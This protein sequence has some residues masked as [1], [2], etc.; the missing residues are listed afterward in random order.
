M[1]NF[2]HRERALVGY[3]NKDQADSDL[4]TKQQIA[5]IYAKVAAYLA[6]NDMTKPL[7]FDT[8]T[9]GGGRDDQMIEIAICDSERTLIVDTLVYTDRPSNPEAFK[10]HGIP[11]DALIGK[12]R[13]T[14][15]Q[16]A[17]VS[18]LKSRTLYAYNIAFDVRIMRQSAEKL[19]LQQVKQICLAKQFANFI[20]HYSPYFKANRYYSLSKAMAYFGVNHT[21]AHRAAPDALA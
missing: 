15:I 12:P 7:F 16:E 13:F 6:T 3:D 11:P 2:S 9:T 19:R 5:A 14:E 17:I 18:L 10:V 1:D 4:S 21:N 8:E 20:G